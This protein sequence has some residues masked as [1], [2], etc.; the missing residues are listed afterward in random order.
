MGT[1]TLRP[2]GVYTAS[3][4]YWTAVGAASH[5][6]ATSDNSDASYS[7]D[8]WAEAQTGQYVLHMTT[9]ALPALSQVRTVTPRLRHSTDTLQNG[10]QVMATLYYNKNGTVYGA[11]PYR[12]TITCASTATTTY[13]FSSVTTLHDGTPWLQEQIDSMLFDFVGFQPNLVGG[14]GQANHRLYEVY[15]DVVYNEVPTATVTGPAEGANLTDTSQP[16]VTWT[17]SDAEG[18]AQERYQVSIQNTAG[19]VTYWESGE[20]LSSATSRVVDIALPNG[21]YKA[22]VRVADVGSGGR[23]SNWDSNTFSLNVTPPPVPSQ[24][25]TWQDPV[26]RVKVDVTQGGTTPATEFYY[27]QYRDQDVSDAGGPWTFLRGGNPLLWTA[28]TTTI[29]DYETRPG[30]R[31]SYRSAAGRTVSGQPFVSAYSGG[32]YIDPPAASTWSLIDPLN[33]ALL[34]VDF[35]DGELLSTR[36]ETQTV[37][38]PL[39]R[40]R[41]V[42]QAG[43]ITGE[44]GQLSLSFRDKTA[45]DA[46]EAL[47][48]TQR[49]LWFVTPYPGVSM[50]IRLGAARAARLLLGGQSRKVSPKRLVTIG[51]I[52]V[53]RPT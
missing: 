5:D 1:F 50:Y 42:V 25:L 18:D 31:R 7:N 47:R 16:T 22:L 13:T 14:A 2:D 39:G 41:V 46:F 36:P 34:Q 44:E 40:T 8:I 30:V 48:G 29:Y 45:F 11:N 28:A 49:T 51:F 33:P 21:N 17:Y 52:E 3:G 12:S 10:T 53:D 9:S 20:V 27:V 4:S 43:T 6:A 19:T 37:F 26:R 35:Q 15:V 23:Y 24:I 32:T 38:R